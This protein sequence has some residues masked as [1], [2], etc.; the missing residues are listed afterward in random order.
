LIDG[1]RDV[2]TVAAIFGDRASFDDLVALRPADA[3]MHAVGE[4][5]ALG[6]V[7][8]RGDGV[9]F[10]HPLYAH[11]LRTGWRAPPARYRQ[12]RRAIATSV[13]KVLAL[14]ARHLIE[15]GDETPTH[16]CSTPLASVRATARSPDS[17]G[18]TPRAAMR[19]PPTWG[20]GS[21][22]PIGI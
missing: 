5:E 17:H 10:T 2:L 19:G 6:V 18:A 1:D 20:R 21:A 12:R 11:L 8:R 13:Q 14:V 9:R 16:A 15:A 3:V 7:T 4:G 22:F